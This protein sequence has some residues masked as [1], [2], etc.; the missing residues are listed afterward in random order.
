[1]LRHVDGGHYYPVAAMYVR[2]EDSAAPAAGAAIGVQ[3]LDPLNRVSFPDGSDNFPAGTR[4]GAWTALARVHPDAIFLAQHGAWTEE[5]DA[6][7][8]CATAVLL[9]CME[10][11]QLFMS[12][13]AA[14]AAQAMAAAAQGLGAIT[15]AT[16]TYLASILRC[17]VVALYRGTGDTVWRM[18]MAS[19]SLQGDATSIARF[20]K[21]LAVV[22]AARRLRAIMDSDDPDE[23]EVGHPLFHVVAWLHLEAEGSGFLVHA[24]P[25]H[26][27]AVPS[28]RVV[29]RWPLPMGARVRSAAQLYG[30]D[31]GFR[32]PTAVNEA[33]RRRGPETVGDCSSSL[34]RSEGDLDDTLCLWCGADCAMLLLDSAHWMVS[35][36]RCAWPL[37]APVAC[38]VCDRRYDGDYAPDDGLPA[39]PPERSRRPICCHTELWQHQYDVPDPTRGPGV[40]WSCGARG[41]LTHTWQG[42]SDASV[43]QAVGT[44]ACSHCVPVRGLGDASTLWGPGPGF[45][46]Q[47]EWTQHEPGMPIHDMHSLR[48]PRVGQC[49]GPW[50]ARELLWLGVLWANLPPEVFGRILRFAGLPLSRDADDPDAPRALVMRGIHLEYSVY[51]PVHTPWATVNSIVAAVDA[52][53]HRRAYGRHDV[54]CVR[55]G[56]RAGGCG[57]C[58]GGLPPVAAS[59]LRCIRAD[60]VWA[61]ELHEVAHGLVNSVALS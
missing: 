5:V 27:W 43:A 7:G 3:A 48:Q 28:A 23:Q 31:W 50:T 15:P 38:W 13:E 2:V 45:I 55:C 29:P 47:A 39:A 12:A 51:A 24:V 9:E 36:W 34:V 54:G 42:A 17:E 18:P 35:C 25:L 1:M 21:L 49:R 33:A 46:V 40:C 16:W 53:R 4:V 57:L 6:S 10:A 20:C 59:Y 41:H 32:M 56:F 19:A 37:D 8:A 30:V 14:Q 61:V 58:A 26:G 60:G 11:S 52:L 44:G 22:N